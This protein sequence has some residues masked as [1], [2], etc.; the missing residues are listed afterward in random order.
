[1]VLSV[2]AWS[3]WMTTGCRWC[4]V[5]ECRPNQQQVSDAEHTH[6][7]WTAAGRRDRWCRAVCGQLYHIH[8]QSRRTSLTLVVCRPRHTSLQRCA[9][10]E[11]DV[12]CYQQR[13][14]PRWPGCHCHSW[15]SA[16]LSPAVL[17]HRRVLT[18]DQSCRQPTSR[19]CLRRHSA[20]SE[21]RYHDNAMRSWCSR[22]AGDVCRGG[23][24]RPCQRHWSAGLWASDAA[25][26]PGE[27][28]C[29]LSGYQT[30]RMERHCDQQTYRHKTYR[31]LCA[32]QTSSPVTRAFWWWWWWPS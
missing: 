29:W 1:M 17:N 14:L 30:D 32:V 6:Q 16:A 8:V 24:H 27:G 21:S 12:D 15:R 23:W 5:V 13:T 19:G 25:G 18:A 20:D 2:S 28:Q 11:G 7:W 22:C 26:E 9:D 4:V 10:S 3:S 31:R